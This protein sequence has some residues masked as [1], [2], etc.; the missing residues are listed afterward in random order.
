[1]LSCVQLCDPM[2]C[3]PPG[4]SVH[5]IFQPRILEWVATS[6]SRGSS[7]LTQGLNPSLLGLLHW[8]AASLPLAPSGKPFIN[9]LF[10][11]EQWLK[12]KSAKKARSEAVGI[13]H[14]FPAVSPTQ[15]GEGWPDLTRSHA[16]KCAVVGKPI[17]SVIA[18]PL[19]WSMVFTLCVCALR[20]VWGHHC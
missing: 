6:S 7:I 8:Q 2:D 16:E 11:N 17:W 15:N 9:Q 1:M 5:G 13:L 14:I 3:W 12:K 19:S 10:P 20:S 18:H 4:S